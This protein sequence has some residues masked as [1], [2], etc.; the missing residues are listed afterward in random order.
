MTKQ[1]WQPLLHVCARVCKNGII[2]VDV[3]YL[4]S[5]SGLQIYRFCKWV[6]TVVCQL[7]CARFLC[8]QNV[9]SSFKKV[10]HL[11]L[12]NTVFVNNN[13]L[14]LVGRPVHENVKIKRKKKQIWSRLAILLEIVVWKKLIK[15]KFLCAILNIFFFL[16]N[17]LLVSNQ[18]LLVCLEVEGAVIKQMQFTLTRQ[19]IKIY[20]HQRSNTS[21]ENWAYFLLYKSVADYR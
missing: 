13:F 5:M 14:F 1:R 10:F 21:P 11:M 6:D 8:I 20:H 2:C 12:W 9:Q 15:H 19:L 17:L 7:D 18:L 16:L 4:I 3:R